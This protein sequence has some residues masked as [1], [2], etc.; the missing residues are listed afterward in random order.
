MYS[1]ELC[2]CDKVGTNVLIS[3]SQGTQNS[4]GLVDSINREKE[5][6]REA[7][8]LSKSFQ[9]DQVGIFCMDLY[10]RVLNL[11]ST[12]LILLI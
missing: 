5:A 6:K 12:F 8:L 9:A 10:E 4:V 11:V 2:L 7:P 1:L 3:V